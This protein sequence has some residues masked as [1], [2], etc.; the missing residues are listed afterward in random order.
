MLG[1]GGGCTYAS[2]GAACIFRFP[3]DDDGAPSSPPRYPPAPRPLPRSSPRPLAPLP[4]AAL[5]LRIV[6]QPKA[7]QAKSQAR[8]NAFVELTERTRDMPKED[9]KADFGQKGMIRQGVGGS[10]NGGSR[11]PPNPSEHSLRK[12]ERVKN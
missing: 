9:L 7:R 1:G 8:V 11:G 4:S 3:E 2:L 6:K 12:K 5:T 10:V